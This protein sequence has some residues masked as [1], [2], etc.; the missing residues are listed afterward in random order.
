[1]KQL[2]RFLLIIIILQISSPCMALRWGF[3]EKQPDHPLNR[4]RENSSFF[5]TPMPS[6]RTSGQ[7]AFLLL[8]CAQARLLNKSKRPNPLSLAD[9][10]NPKNWIQQPIACIDDGLIGHPG[11]PPYGM[12]GTAWTWIPKIDRTLIAVDNAKR[13]MDAW[14]AWV[15]REL[16][17]LDNSSINFQQKWNQ[18]VAWG[19][20]VYHTSL[21]G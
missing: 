18:F 3:F 13:R 5:S 4:K 11:H 19:S 20:N 2:T 6:I 21:N 14:A 16:R 15:N 7:A 8:L 1:M 17:A 10:C 12:L 9:A